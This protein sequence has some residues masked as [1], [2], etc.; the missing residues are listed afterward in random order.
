MIWSVN[1]VAG[2]IVMTWVSYHFSRYLYQL[3]ENDMWFSEIMVWPLPQPPSI[4]NITL[5][6]VEREISFRTEQGL[7]YSYY[8]Q[9]VFAPS[10]KEGFLQLKQDNLT[11]STNTVNMFER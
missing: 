8:K 6:E 10:L 1:T 4:L 11:E 5:Q 3:H 9:L 7:Y 2:Y